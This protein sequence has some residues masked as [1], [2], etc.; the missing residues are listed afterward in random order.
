ME[1]GPIKL[2]HKPVFESEEI[3]G[4]LRKAT[5]I[6]EAASSGFKIVG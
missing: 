6:V 5:H 1:V 2:F 3:Y 4:V